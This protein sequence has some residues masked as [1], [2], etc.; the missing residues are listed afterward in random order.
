MKYTVTTTI[1]AAATGNGSA[2]PFTS[3]IITDT[4][5]GST[6]DIDESTVEVK[7]GTDKLTEETQY[8][9]SYENSVLT[10]TLIDTE[11]TG[12][13]EELNKNLNTKNIITVTYEATVATDVNFSTKLTNTAEATYQRAGMTEPAKATVAANSSNTVDLYT[14]GLDLT[15]TLSDGGT[16]TAN[17]ISF[18]L[19]KTY[20]SG[21]FSDPVPIKS[22]TGGYWQTVSDTDP[23]KNTYTMYVG[24]NGSLNLY[25]LEPGTYYLKET[26]TMEGYTL[27]DEPI[28]IVITATDSQQGGDPIMTATVNTADA[29]VTNGVVS[30]SVENTKNEAGF[31]LPVTGDTGTLLVTAI[32]L[33]LLCAGIILLVVYRRKQKKN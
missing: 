31:T 12:G 7:L 8:S 16:I 4:N 28:T 18:E 26:A 6:L 24:T 2:T 13:L 21:T 25:G 32:G 27:L 33:G 19:Y 10:I 20:S 15:K 1:P 22:G 30:L 9:V 5:T 29:Q 11:T 23:D 14:Y 17:K 3:F